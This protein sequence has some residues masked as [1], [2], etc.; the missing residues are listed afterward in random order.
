MFPLHASA[1]HF[2]PSADVSRTASA[3]VW[4]L[5]VESG[6]VDVEFRIAL[7]ASHVEG[8]T[9]ARRLES[10]LRH[11]WHTRRRYSYGMDR[12]I[13]RERLSSPGSGL[14]SHKR[15]YAAG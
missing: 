6:K 1:S 10:K 5:E 7:Q 13:R 4:N 12:K 3:L 2:F 8:R 9:V 14:R 11:G 15:I